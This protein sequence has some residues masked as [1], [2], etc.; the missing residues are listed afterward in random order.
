M[1]VFD[2]LLSLHKDVTGRSAALASSCEALVAE[3]ASLE[4]FG[5]SLRARL[6]FFDELEAVGEQFAALQVR[7]PSALLGLVVGWA[8]CGCAC[9]I[10]CGDDANSH[11][12]DVLCAESAGVDDAERW[13]G[14]K[15]WRSG[16]RGGR[17]GTGGCSYQGIGPMR[18]A[19]RVAQGVWPDW[20]FLTG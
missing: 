5:N 13:K 4:E 10:S 18:G 12:L 16:S 17:Q 19:A 14:W 7:V 1:A 15:G 2:Q 9:G 11:A 20:P 8:C 6:K 3:K